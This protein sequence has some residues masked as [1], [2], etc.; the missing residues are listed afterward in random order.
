[1]DTNKEFFIKF[2][3]TQGVE[4]Y[5]SKNDEKIIRNFIIFLCRYY[6][7]SSEQCK[8]RLLNVKLMIGNSNKNLGVFKDMDEQG[9]I[10]IYCKHIKKDLRKILIVIAH[11]MTHAKQLGF[12]VLKWALTENQVWVHMWNEDYYQTTEEYEMHKNLPW[13]QEAYAVQESLVDKFVS[14]IC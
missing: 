5:V 11:E 10:E 7:L 4:K 9:V 3:Q 1:M 8:Y 13:E 12:N 14:S 2:R 6:K